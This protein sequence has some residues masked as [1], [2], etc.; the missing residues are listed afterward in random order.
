MTAMAGLEQ[1]EASAARSRAMISWTRLVVAHRRPVLATWVILLLLGGW[2]TSDLGRLLT[3]R[4]SVPGSDA[5]R[6]LDILRSHFH[7]RGDGAFTL[8][9][10]SSAR[11]AELAG[12][13]AAAQRAAAQVPGGK[14]GPPRL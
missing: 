8:V 1:P 9:V 7:E 5:E 2:A 6:G 10:Q 3:N 4:F 12:T 13:E 14:A 11:G